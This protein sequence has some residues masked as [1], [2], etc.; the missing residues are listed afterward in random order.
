MT[1]KLVCLQ[2]QD[3]E[4]EEHAE[5]TVMAGTEKLSEE[6]K[7]HALCAHEKHI[8]YMICMRLMRLMHHLQFA[9][10]D[11]PAGPSLHVPP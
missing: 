3:G 7:D 10:H 9:S 5:Q 4:E 11:A 2:L 1:Q 8:I 6:T